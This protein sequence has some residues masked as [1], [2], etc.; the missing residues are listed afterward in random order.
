MPASPQAVERV[1]RAQPTWFF[2]QPTGQIIAVQEEEAW[3]LYT[4]K[5]QIIGQRMYPPKI[6]G[7]GTG[8][9]YQK[10]V[11]EAI[12]LKKAGDLEGAQARLRLGYDEELEESRKTIRAPRNFDMIDRNG[13]ATS[14]DQLQRII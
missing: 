3:R 4:G 10:A 5:N 14:I 2:E 11:S 13:R 12:A 7:V 8:L 1:E 6:I 9:L